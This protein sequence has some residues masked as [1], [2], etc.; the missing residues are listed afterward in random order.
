MR[1]RWPSFRLKALF[2]LLIPNQEGVINGAASARLLVE[3]GPGFGKTDV[4]CARIVHLLEQ[5]S[6]PSGIVL[7]TFTRTAVREIR[8][9][10]HAL[11]SSGTELGGVEVRTLDSFAWRLRRGLIEMGKIVA[12][13]TSYE[14]T[15]TVLREVLS[16]PPGDEIR[17]RVM[18]YLCGKNHILI[19]EAQD[20]VG[21]R[22]AFVMD[23][24][25]MVPKECGWTVFY[26]PAQAIYDWSEA[27]NDFG[28]RRAKIC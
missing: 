23:L 4:A 22:S 28:R 19:D 9:R 18:E 15:F 8:D 5:G 27:E 26:D 25:R 1:R 24:L 12:G 16:R 21:G 6:P 3:A 14:Q 20:L 2:A 11:A 7:L 13:Q 10:I 17:G